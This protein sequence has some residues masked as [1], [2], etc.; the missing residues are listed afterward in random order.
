[1]S[2]FRNGG[3]FSCFKNVYKSGIEEV[4]EKGKVEKRETENWIGKKSF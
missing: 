2:F 4:G 1:M 3:H